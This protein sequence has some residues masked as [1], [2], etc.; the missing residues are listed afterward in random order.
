MS[1]A[2]RVALPG[3]D[4]IRGRLQDMVLD[5]RYPSPKIDV[6][7]RP[8]H[9]GIISIYWNDTT[10]IAND[11]TRLIYPFSHGYN[12]T[13]TAFASYRFDSGSS[14]IRGT[15]P[16]QYGSI[17]MITI[18]TDRENVNLKYHST[19]LASVTPIPAFIMQVRFYV[20]AE[21]GYE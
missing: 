2:F 15:L 5:A 17:G 14:I 7:A 10:A 9:A 20:M 19:D 11:T 1:Q 18:D 8:P 16:F 6:T 13:P 4:A 12:Y 3:Q 21:R